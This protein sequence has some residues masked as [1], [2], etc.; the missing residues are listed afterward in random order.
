MKPK[1]STPYGVRR[2]KAKGHL[3]PRR[4]AGSRTS[5]NRRFFNQYGTGRN[6][7]AVRSIGLG[8]TALPLFLAL[9][10]AARAQDAALAADPAAEPTVDFTADEVIYDSGAEQLTASGQVRMSRDG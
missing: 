4:I 1:F 3:V 7:R 5:C 8:L 10:P 6:L 9:A 2:A